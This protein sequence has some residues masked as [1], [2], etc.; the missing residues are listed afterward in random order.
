MSRNLYNSNSNNN[1]DSYPITGNPVD[2]EILVFQNNQF[3]YSPFS[4]LG[5]NAVTSVGI[6]ASIIKSLSGGTLTLKTI[7]GDENITISISTDEVIVNLN[8]NLT[9]LQSIQ[10][11]PNTDLNVNI[12]DDGISADMRSIK[13]NGKYGI[14]DTTNFLEVTNLGKVKINNIVTSTSPS[15]NFLCLDVQNNIIQAP[16]SGTEATTA[17]N[18]GTGTGTIF[19]QEVGNDLQFKTLKEPVSGNIDLTNGADEIVIDLGPNLDNISTINQTHPNNP[20]TIFSQLYMPNVAQENSGN[21]YN[22]CLDN[23]NKVIQIPNTD[24]VNLGTGSQIFKNKNFENL[25]F[26]SIL[27]DSN[28]SRTTNTNDITLGLNSNLDLNVLNI[29]SSG[30]PNLTVGSPMFLTDSNIPDKTSNLKAL[31]IE[32]TGQ[33]KKGYPITSL[34]QS[35]FG[36]SLINSVTNGQA[37]LKTVLSS[38]N[39]LTVGGNVSMIDLT[40]NNS[41][42]F[43]TDISELNANLNLNSTNTYL[44][45][46]PVQTSNIVYDLCV[47]NTG[48]IVKTNLAPGGQNIYNSDGTLTS[49]IR[50]VT[51]LN[52]I[53]NGNEN[54]LVFDKIN[55]GLTGNNPAYDPSIF[56]GVP[57]VGLY[58]ADKFML[59]GDLN[60]YTR[61]L[62][63]PYNYTSCQFNF[64]LGSTYGAGYNLAK[65]STSPTTN[66][67]NIEIEIIQTDVSPGTLT[68]FSGVW[69]FNSNFENIVPGVPQALKPISC[70]NAS[71]ILQNAVGLEIQWDAGGFI[72]RARQISRTSGAISNYRV[73]FKEKGDG[74]IILSG[75][76]FGAVGANNPPATYINDDIIQSSGLGLI[77]SILFNQKIIG[78]S[79]RIRVMQSF[80][81]NQNNSSAN[82]NV[83]LN[84]TI[85]FT[86]NMYNRYANTNPHA[87]GEQVF[88]WNQLMNLNLLS[89]TTSNTISFT[90]TGAGAANYVATA[91]NPYRFL[92]TYS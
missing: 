38:N 6:G 88:S 41:Q 67:F 58:R 50:T 35:G 92:M 80:D 39:S 90:V 76:N 63:C 27:T 31:F 17:S 40:L 11:D 64:T 83:L 53:V 85:I 23:T 68:P 8:P 70:V 60:G 73:F 26:R 13:F 32:S 25:Q 15:G 18:I 16:T 24:G 61:G 2:G 84:G 51:G 91:F 34:T 55:F 69:Q 74:N 5:I 56:M 36:G 45:N 44:P 77:P 59:T 54:R 65:Y 1:I 82:F 28:I 9:L 89:L 21:T 87:Q 86:I 46:T 30:T 71:S 33:I 20:T 75:Y 10:N 57:I 66:A 78:K 81:N 62:F 37:I 72:F 22:L 48:R 42:Q 29:N 4:A 3:V 12:F 47:D 19:A 49:G 79:V 52:T 14:V 7:Y 43:I